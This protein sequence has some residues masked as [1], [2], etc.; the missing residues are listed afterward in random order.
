M[1]IPRVFVS[2]GGF[3]K[4]PLDAVRELRAAGVADIELSGGVHQ[5]G[6]TAGL[7]RESGAGRLQVH[8]YF[9]PPPVPFVFNLCDPDERGRERSVQFA[10]DAV[11]LSASLGSHVYSFHAG[12]LGTP[13]VSDLGRNWGVLNKLG[14]DEG[15]EL[16]AGSVARVN[17]F[18]RERGVRLLV[19]NN[20]LTIGTATANGE[21][22][23]LMTSA[24]SIRSI[25]ACLPADIGLLMDVAHFAVSAQTLGFDA[26]SSLRDLAPLIGGYHLSDNDGL[27]DNNE[28]VREDSWFWNDLNAEVPYATLE[29]HPDKVGS[30][31]DQVALTERKL[32]DRDQHP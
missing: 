14:L 27:S 28:P 5:G 31:A 22:V 7:T 9:P 4:P 16:F 21:D 17:N 1:P 18:A 8:N 6:V 13:T 30:Y 2:S 25:L 15:I 29:I 26:S 23:L 24:E 3:G 11:E 20:V 10:C 32:A 12:F 19:E